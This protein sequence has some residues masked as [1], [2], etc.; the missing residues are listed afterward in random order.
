MPDKECCPECAKSV[1][2]RAAL[3]SHLSWGH[4]ILDP[5]RYLAQLE[6]MARRRHRFHPL[7]RRRVRRAERVAVHG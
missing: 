5:D 6:R 2:S 1:L 7:A 4:E 3:T